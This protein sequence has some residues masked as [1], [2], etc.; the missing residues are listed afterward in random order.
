M[1]MKKKVHGRDMLTDI[2]PS[3]VSI[4]ELIN[5]L[6]E[7]KWNPSKLSKNYKITYKD[8]QLS[9][10]ITSLSECN[11]DDEIIQVIKDNILKLYDDKVGKRYTCI[12]L[13]AYAKNME[14]E[15]DVK[16]TIKKLCEKYKKT[17]HHTQQKKIISNALKDGKYLK[18]INSDGTIVHAQFFLNWGYYYECKY[19]HD[20]FKSYKQ[21][22]ISYEEKDWYN[23]AYRNRH[24]L[25][26]N[27][28]NGTK[29]NFS[30]PILIHKKIK[31]DGK[32]RDVYSVEKKSYEYIAIKYIKKRLD[33]E[34]SIKYANRS[35][36]MLELFQLIENINSLS[37]YTIFRFDIKDFFESVDA[38][39]VFEKYIIPSSLDNECKI[40]LQSLI[41]YNPKCYAG[42]ATSNA[43]I[44]IV[45]QRF[46]N[47]LR[48]KL[49]K[50][51]IIFYSRYV[52][53]GVIILNKNVSKSILEELIKDTVKS[54]FGDNVCL[55]PTKR[56]YLVKTDKNSEFD[57]LGY[58]FVKDNDK[59][60]YGITEEKRDK[61]QKRLDDIVSDY[62]LKPNIELL[63]Q[64]IV[65]FISRTVFYNNY[66]SRYS[67]L[68]S[69]DVTGITSNYCLLKNA[70]KYEKIE[71]STN[72]YIKDMIYATLCRKL[73]GNLPYFINS[74]SKSWYNIEYGIVHNKS[75]VFHPKI[76]W[77][78]KYLCEQIRKLG[79]K[80]KLKGKSYR[81]CIAIYYSII[82]LQR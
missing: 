18:L 9:L 48:A 46:D 63:R 6:R 57:Y 44:E 12:Y 76:G 54:N 14:I 10:I 72:R 32:I 75:I 22:M 71:R 81:E 78:S 39:F 43:L 79:Y 49:H 53:D 80:G 20:I 41:E 66:S 24:M 29:M 1:R 77:S 67:N 3:G 52:D 28:I 38:K 36:I 64:R 40:L 47:C 69:W 45:G 31:K 37:M 42:L 34:F 11:S 25:Y 56:N 33:I 62:I 51:G 7:K 2:I 21:Y 61:Y 73:G 50:Y 59:Y 35:H 23:E 4:Q 74:K 68:G 60:K 30:K 15:S 82:K 26:Y 17:Y 58:L 13:V 19:L 70:I 65:Y 5:K 16:Q 8:C 27:I 55:H